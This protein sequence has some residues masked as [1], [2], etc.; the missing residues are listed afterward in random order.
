M[1][2]R[3]L[4]PMLN[5]WPSFRATLKDFVV[6]PCDVVKYTYVAFLSFFYSLSAVEGTTTTDRTT[7]RTLTL[8]AGPSRSLL[9]R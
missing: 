6:F 1:P 4:T 3:Y 2:L 7:D 5:L 9:S 8:V